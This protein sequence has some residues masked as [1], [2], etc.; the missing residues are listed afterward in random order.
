VTAIP[1]TVT[2]A[3]SLFGQGIVKCL[4]K[5]DLH[6]SIQGLDYFP[7]AVG[8]RWCD[9]G[10]LLPDLL[11]PSVSEDIWF[12]ALCRTVS[13]HG[14]RFLF[15]G[16]DFELVPLAR[17]SAH[18]LERT[19]CRAIVSH[20]QL[21]EACKD[22]H[23][24]AG[25]LS[26]LG[27]PAPKTFLPDEGLERIERALGYPMIVK[28]RFGSRSRGVVR[29]TDRPALERALRETPQ[30]V[31]QQYLPDEEAEFSC[32]VVCFDGVVDS[33]AIL[34]RRL[35]DGN[36][37]IAFSEECADLEIFCRKVGNLLKP[38]GP[39]NIQLRM[40]DKTPCI[41]EI[42]PRFSGTTV[43]R[44][45][46]GINEPVRILRHLLGLPVEPSPRLRHGRVLRYFEELVEFAD[47]Q[48][49]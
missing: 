24:T 33:V 2:G 43:F 12:D 48:A 31:V 38:F 23:A 29:V 22:K 13:A 21:V 17:R 14:S 11:D 46:L 7:T 1:I 44:A 10:D 9:K 16:A 20:L 18:L 37:V 45:L 26:S 8:L 36:T 35:K 32:G 5:S 41:F 3:G 39:L 25:L 4:R 49:S 28:P 34:R 30:P 6:I 42:N 19:G 15:V 47:A 27:V 40:T